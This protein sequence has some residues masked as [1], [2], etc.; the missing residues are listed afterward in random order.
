MNDKYPLV[1]CTMLTYKKFKHLYEAL[2]SV[3]MQDYPNIELIIGDDGSPLFPLKEIDQYIESN[4]S[5]N[6]SN[7]IVYTN[8]K[9]LGTVKNVNRAYKMANGVYLIGLS[10]DDVFYASNVISEVVKRFQDT[11]WD[12]ISCRRL[13]CKEESLEPIIHIPEDKYLKKISTLNTAEKQYLA[14]ARC[15]YY[16]MASGSTTYQTRSNIKKYN[17]FDEDYFLWE[18]G[19]FYARYTRNGN[20]IHTAYDIVAI[21]YR[22]GGIS[23]TPR[24]QQI[25]IS[26]LMDL[27]LQLYYTKE[28]EPFMVRFNK[29]EMRKVKYSKICLFNNT[30]RFTSILKR[31]PYIDVALAN[32]FEKRL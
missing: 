1:T 7:V 5:E 32:L 14:F 28:I 23:T 29:K 25:K 21:K 12:L 26:S 31:L 13:F 4:K 17:Y 30:N 9:N 27:D 20:L 24:K 3:F 6:V 11:G 2:D 18:D 22:E 10:C 15:Y 19:P 8:D 16:Q